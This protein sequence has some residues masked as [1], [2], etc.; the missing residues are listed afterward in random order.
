[1]QYLNLEEHI[2][3]THQTKEQHIQQITESLTD[4]FQINVQQILEYP[5][6]ALHSLLQIP[7]IP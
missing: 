7:Q 1:M 6:E 5:L 2:I 3:F 4:L